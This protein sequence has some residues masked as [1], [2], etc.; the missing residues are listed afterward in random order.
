MSNPPASPTVLCHDS[1]PALRADPFGNNSNDNPAPAAAA[2]ASWL[3]IQRSIWQEDEAGPWSDLST[4]DLLKKTAMTAAIALGLM[5]E[6]RDVGS[7]DG[8]SP[9]FAEALKASLRAC[10]RLN[11]PGF[12]PSTEF[13]AEASM[14]LGLGASRSP[15]WLLANGI[16]GL[17]PLTGACAKAIE[18]LDHVERFTSREALEAELPRLAQ[19][20][21][22]ALAVVDPS[23]LQLRPATPRSAPR[24]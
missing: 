17:A 14:L 23:F 22:A 4:T 2:E 13:S 16:Y 21:A 5:A 12:P 9:T 8:L 18:A 19:F 6:A 11:I 20:F 1:F 15:A 10:S 7:C 3:G 24:P